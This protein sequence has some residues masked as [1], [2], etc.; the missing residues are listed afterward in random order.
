L[1]VM[2][3]MNIAGLCL[4]RFGLRMM[5]V[6]METEVNRAFPC[7]VHYKPIPLYDSVALQ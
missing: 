1:T 4:S 2:N 3:V 7:D 6:H 5:P